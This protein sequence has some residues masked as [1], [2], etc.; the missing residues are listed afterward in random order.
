MATACIIVEEEKQLAHLVRQRDQAETLGPERRPARNLEQGGAESAVS[1][2]F[3]ARDAALRRR[4]ARPH[5]RTGRARTSRQDEPS[6]ARRQKQGT[7]GEP[8]QGQCRRALLRSRPVESGSAA[9]D[10]AAF[11]DESAV[12]A[13]LPP[14]P[15]GAVGDLSRSAPQALR[16]WVHPNF[17]PTPC[18]GPAGIRGSRLDQ[19]A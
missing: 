4:G 16:R 8:R 7:S 17:S 12:P 11:A 3:A 18:A 10:H 6:R 14:S 5:A 2:P 13:S 15:A 9:W 19:P 1:I